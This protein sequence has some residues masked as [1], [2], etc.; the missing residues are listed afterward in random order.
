MNTRRQVNA[1]AI[2]LV[3][4]ILYLL[5]FSFSRFIL[6]KENFNWNEALLGAVIFGLIFFTI[7][8]TINIKIGEKPVFLSKI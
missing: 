2:G 3:T 8:H 1:A 5:V 4:S 7:Q 6:T